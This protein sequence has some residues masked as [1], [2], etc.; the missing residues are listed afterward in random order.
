MRRHET[1][2][3]EMKLCNT[4]MSVLLRYVWCKNIVFF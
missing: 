2:T 4:K 1:V 3:I